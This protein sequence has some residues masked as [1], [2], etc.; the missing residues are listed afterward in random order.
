LG[1][2]GSRANGRPIADSVIFLVGFGL[3][4]VSLT[5]ARQR[6]C[7]KGGGLA[8][9][10]AGLV[11]AAAAS[12][13][14][15]V[16][17]GIVY[18][19]ARTLT[20][21]RVGLSV[22][23]FAQVVAWVLLAVAAFQRL[24]ELSVGPVP[25]SGSSAGN[26]YGQSPYGP[27]ARTDRSAQLPSPGWVPQPPTWNPQPAPGLVPQS[28]AFADPPPGWTGAAQPRPTPPGVPTQ[29]P[30]Q[31]TSPHPQP[32]VLSAPPGQWTPQPGETSSPP[33]R[34]SPT[35]MSA[36]GAD[37]EH[38]A[39][40]RVHCG[41]KLQPGTRFCPMCGRPVARLTA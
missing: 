9:L 38:S 5:L 20:T 8:T 25:G 24:A 17:Y 34:P 13:V 3:L 11:A 18:A 10:S 7:V 6:G 33:P 40:Q 31:S 12:V 39:S 35:E 2:S 37:P 15:A 1:W 16:G 32:Q 41:V 29:P 4:N 36:T 21:V 27:P 26:S 19:P 30:W 22:P 28:P 14:A 23:Q